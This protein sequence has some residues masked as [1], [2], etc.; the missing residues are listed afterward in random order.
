MKKAGGKK[1]ASFQE[2]WQSSAQTWLVHLLDFYSFLCWKKNPQKRTATNVTKIRRFQVTGTSAV[3]QRH[4]SNPKPR[5]KSSARPLPHVTFITLSGRRINNLSRSCPHF[6][7]WIPWTTNKE[8]ISLIAHS[9]LWSVSFLRR[10][11]RSVFYLGNEIFSDLL[12]FC[13]STGGGD[14]A[15]E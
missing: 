11:R 8:L 1:Q 13:P 5:G 4:T 12:L 3:R 15:A 2:G 9:S 10:T 7:Q 14:P 6:L